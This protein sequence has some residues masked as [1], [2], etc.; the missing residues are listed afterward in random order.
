VK[1]SDLGLLE[2]AQ[3]FADFGLTPWFRADPKPVAGRIAGWD[4]HVEGRQHQGEERAAWL[5]KNFSR[6][7][8]TNS[9]MGLSYLLP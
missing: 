7:N 2:I 3:S 8:E 1:G 4:E 5:M 9:S 6:Y